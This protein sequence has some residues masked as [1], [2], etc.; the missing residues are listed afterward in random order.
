MI[1]NLPDTD[2]L[3]ETVAK[4]QDELTANNTKLY[5]DY[6]DGKYGY[7]TDPNRG[8]DTFNPFKSGGSITPILLWTNPNNAYDIGTLTLNIDFSNYEAII[9]IAKE[10]VNITEA[11]TSMCYMPIPCSQSPLL[12]TYSG[13]TN[14]VSRKVTVT[15]NSIYF[16]WAK[17][18]NA[19]INRACIP[20]EIYGIEKNFMSDL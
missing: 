18:N 5:F 7:N 6:K 9:I 13:N 12:T 3:T 20:L 8:A 11:M 16:D 17:Y 15:S 14:G 10:S 2:E 4:I 1:I 19:E